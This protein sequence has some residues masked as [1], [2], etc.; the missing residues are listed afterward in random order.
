MT[1]STMNTRMTFPRVFNRSAA[2]TQLRLEVSNPR[3][4]VCG[5]RSLSMV[6][7]RPPPAVCVGVEFCGYTQRVFSSH[8]N[9]RVQFKFFEVGETGFNTA[10]PFERIGPG[11]SEN[12]TA[13]LAMSSTSS[14]LSGRV[15]PSMRPFHPW[16][17][18]RQV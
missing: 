1:S 8:G 15:F 16:R 10:V 6:L 11:G 3:S 12:S 14:N 7:E 4:K 13:Q 17:K 9:Q 18:P 2:S 5:R